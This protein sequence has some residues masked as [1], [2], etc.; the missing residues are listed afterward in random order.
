MRST[1]SALCTHG[2]FFPPAF[3]SFTATALGPVITPTHLNDCVSPTGLPAST[4]AFFQAILCRRPKWSPKNISEVLWGPWVKPSAGGSHFLPWPWMVRCGLAARIC[5]SSPLT[6]K[7]QLHQPSTPGTWQ[8][9]PTSGIPHLPFPGLISL[10]LTLWVAAL[11]HGHRS[12]QMSFSPANLVWPRSR[13]VCL[14][15]TYSLLGHSG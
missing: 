3:P 1:S 8:A 7:F 14:S 2:D 9:L 12:A 10:T 13:H 15:P 4:L 11:S 5:S 6:H